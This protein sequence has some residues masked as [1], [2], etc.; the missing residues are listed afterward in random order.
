MNEYT[1]WVQ[2]FQSEYSSQT[3]STK[4]EAAGYIQS[5]D[6]AQSVTVEHDGEEI[7]VTDGNDYIEWLNS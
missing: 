6:A 4:E 3:F 7:D 1:V 5:L 2:N